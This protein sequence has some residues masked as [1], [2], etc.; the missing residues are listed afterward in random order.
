MGGRKMLRG[1]YIA[2]N[3]MD[4]Q[5][6]RLNTIS[7]NLANLSTAGYKRNNVVVENFPQALQMAVEAN[8]P[9]GRR[10]PIG[11]GNL[12]NMVSQ[13]Y[14][15]FTQ[16][17]LIETDTATDFALQGKGFFTV[18]SPDGNQY[19]TRDGAFHLDKDGSLVNSDGYK[20]LGEDGPITIE[21]PTNLT[22]KEDGTIVTGKGKETEEVGKLRIT[23][24]ENNSQLKKV[25]GNYFTDPGNTG[26]PAA[27]TR[28]A[29]GTLERTNV[30]PVKELTD[31]IPV[32]RIYESS[33]RIVQVNDEL[34]DKSINQVGRVK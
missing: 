11:N 34:L 7:N 19:Y 15:D 27:A 9:K 25:E 18:E 17:S 28:V 16:G 12:G 21:N 31:M 10:Q 14:L 13:V 3:G 1:L 24:F 8:G 4:V 5:Q 33:Q 6:A 2:M 30:D 22:V 20:V 29:Q 23:E 26:Q 32:T